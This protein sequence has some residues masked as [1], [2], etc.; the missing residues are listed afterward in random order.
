MELVE[1]D[2]SMV[3]AVGY[4]P[5]SEELELVYNSGQVWRYAGVKQEVY[6]GLLAA[7]SKGRYIREYILDCYPEYPVSRP[8]RRR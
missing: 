6:D 2:S 5:E 7:D 8:R 3:R 1:V 4:D